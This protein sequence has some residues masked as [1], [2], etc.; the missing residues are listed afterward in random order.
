MN[1]FELEDKFSTQFFVRRSFRLQQTQGRINSYLP[2][3][4]VIGLS[5]TVHHSVI[6]LR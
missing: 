4:I 6:F 5:S 3:T 1:V 2:F